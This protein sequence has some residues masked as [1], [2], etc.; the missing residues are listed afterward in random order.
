L[1]K[2]TKSP[3]PKSIRS[4]PELFSKNK[5]PNVELKQ[6]FQSARKFS[7]NSGYFLVQQNVF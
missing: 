3:R 2:N 1:K 4:K 5:I 6:C 7:Q